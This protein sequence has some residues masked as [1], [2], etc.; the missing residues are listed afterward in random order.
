MFRDSLLVRQDEKEKYFRTFRER[1]R[2][3]VAQDQ[4]ELVRINWKIM[5]CNLELGEGEKER[6]FNLAALTKFEEVLRTL[7][8]E[9]GDGYIANMNKLAC[10]YYEL[11]EFL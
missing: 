11:E 9:K 4:A 3:Y 2:A 7:E 1:L 5:E 6:Q 8:G 10:S